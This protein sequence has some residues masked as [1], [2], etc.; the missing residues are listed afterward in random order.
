MITTHTIAAS[1]GASLHVESEGSEFL[2]ALMLSNSLGTDLNLWALQVQDFAKSFRVVRY[3]RRGHGRSSLGNAPRTMETLG[4]DALAIM[5]ALG[6]DR[7][8]WCGISMGGMVGQW[9]GA[10]TPERIEKLILS[11]TSA[12]FPN[13]VPWDNRIKAIR[14]NGL[15]SIADAIMTIWFTTDFRAREPETVAQMRAMLCATPVEGYIASCETVRDMDLRA[16]LPGIKA[17][18]LII[19]GQH[20]Q[21]TPL[22]A[23]EYIRAHIGDAE[24]AVLD[25]AHITNVELPATYSDIVEEFLT[26]STR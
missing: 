2:P 9:L 22:E 26:Q 3:D 5:D 23:A 18:T 21:S 13:R 4:R 1:Y 25:A 10:N 12:H 16:L 7:V 20:D 14:E 17:P 19:A 24:L 15:D 6:L 11:N 8:N